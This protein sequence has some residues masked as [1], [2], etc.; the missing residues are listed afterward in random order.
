MTNAE[1]FKAVFGFEPKTIATCTRQYD[2]ETCQKCS[3]VT[4]CAT[5]LHCI[6]YEPPKENN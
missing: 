5:W 4:V 3:S 1:K 6:Q 2:K